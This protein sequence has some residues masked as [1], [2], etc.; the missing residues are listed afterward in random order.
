MAVHEPVGDAPS[1]G[2]AETRARLVDAAIQIA[3]TQGLD[4]VT[5]RSVTAEA[6]L[7]HSLVRFY[8]GTR[9]A[10]VTAALERAAYLDSMEGD[11]NSLDVETFASH[12][13]ESISSNNARGMLQFDNLLRAVRSGEGVNRVVALY[14]FYQ[15]QVSCTLRNLGIPDPDGSVAALVFAA[16][17]G[18]VLQHSVYGSN[19]RTDRV[20]ECLRD[21][22][23]LLEESASTRQDA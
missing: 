1:S 9:E 15:Q 3:S 6:G 7:S 21:V 13:V 16:L 22:L 12:V 2:N 23:R 4:K 17:D 20:L 19:D 18:I 14:D 8:F 10:L 5:Y 11:F